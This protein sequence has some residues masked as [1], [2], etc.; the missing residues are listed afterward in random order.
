MVKII[1]YTHFL[2]MI[3]IFT[4]ACEVEGWGTKQ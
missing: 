3:E 2:A 1:I 4:K